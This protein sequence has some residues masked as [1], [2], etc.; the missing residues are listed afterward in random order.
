MISSHE[1]FYIEILVWLVVGVICLFA[2]L[3]TFFS[4]SSSSYFYGLFVFKCR[5]QLESQLPNI[6]LFI[7]I[8]NSSELG[9]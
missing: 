2:F 1:T 6:I 9:L 8:K 4:Y 3:T 5:F 7:K